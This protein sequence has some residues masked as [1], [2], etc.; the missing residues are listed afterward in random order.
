MQKPKQ[1]TLALATA[2]TATTAPVIE[3]TKSK[4]RNSKKPATVDEPV[5]A[6]V[7]ATVDVVAAT[8]AEPIVPK[9]KT[10]Q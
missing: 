8:V 5:A 3:Q 9:K 10:S 4:K 1:Q 2:A 7:T 6:A